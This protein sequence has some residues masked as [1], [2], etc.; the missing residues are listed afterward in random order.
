MQ[1]DKKEALRYMGYR[2]QQLDK[3]TEALLQ[4][5]CEELQE[6]S[7]ERF[8]YRVFNI[9]AIEESLHLQ[10]TTLRLPGEDI[11]KL[12]SKSQKCVLMAATLGLEVDRRI[13]LY[14]RTNLTK[15]LI[16]DACATAAIESL[17]DT[18]QEQIAAES[19]SLGLNTT[20]RYS[21]GYGD[22]PITVQ[23]EL[24]Q[25]LNAYKEIGLA[26]NDSCIMVPKKSVTAILGLQPGNHSSQQSHCSSCEQKN[27]LYKCNI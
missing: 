7:K 18:L 5:C 19:C 17:C 22:L 13:S 3:N 14:A 11:R 12:L 8:V 20:A 25:V 10:D 2:G 21:P 26:V 4:E 27:C 9:E 6:I 24:L 1:I 23:K 15:G 16:L